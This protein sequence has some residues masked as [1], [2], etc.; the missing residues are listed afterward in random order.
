M[1]QYRRIPQQVL[2]YLIHGIRK[3]NRLW[4]MNNLIFKGSTTTATSFEHILPS[5]SSISMVF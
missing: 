5:I 4:F 2:N 3:Y 1:N